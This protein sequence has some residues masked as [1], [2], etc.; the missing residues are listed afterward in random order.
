MLELLWWYLVYVLEFG[1]ICFLVGLVFDC[2]LLL[3]LGIYFL[4]SIVSVVDGFVLWCTCFVVLIDY[5][6]F[7]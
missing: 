2:L 1:L 3:C 4:L 7:D 5:V 6:Y